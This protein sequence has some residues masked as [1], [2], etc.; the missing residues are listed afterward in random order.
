MIVV[1]MGEVKGSPK[2]LQPDFTPIHFI[3]VI[4]WVVFLILSLYFDSCRWRQTGSNGVGE[5]GR[6]GA[7]LSVIKPA[8]ITV[9]VL[10]GAHS[11]R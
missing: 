1:H 9:S 4:S 5:R 2:V 10:R 11:A 6:H 7:E 8:P 3:V